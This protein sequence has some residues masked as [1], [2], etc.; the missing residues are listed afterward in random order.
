MSTIGRR[1]NS[2]DAQTFSYMVY[3]VEEP[4]LVLLVHTA[5]AQPSLRNWGTGN[6]QAM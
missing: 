6:P 3:H 2:L 1:G 4:T 5:P